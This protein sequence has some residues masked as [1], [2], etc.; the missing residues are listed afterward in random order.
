MRILNQG[1]MQCFKGYVKIILIYE[2][3]KYYLIIIV[4][5]QLILI[6]KN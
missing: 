6:F 5:L 4:T 3:L 2:I 1:L